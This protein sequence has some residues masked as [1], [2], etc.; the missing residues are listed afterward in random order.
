MGDSVRML[1]IIT[2]LP[3]EA[4]S[5]VTQEE[6]AA[7]GW[8]TG[9]QWG[10]NLKEKHGCGSGLRSRGTCP[11]TQICLHRD[12]TSAVV[13]D[14]QLRCEKDTLKIDILKTVHKNLSA[15]LKK[16]L[17]ILLFT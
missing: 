4:L 11:N 9:G 12:Q 2:D 7:P 16:L 6:L 13:R 5:S 17:N 10:R 8:R 1:P 3:E 15:H 14:R